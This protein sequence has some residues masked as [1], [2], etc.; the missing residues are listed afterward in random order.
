MSN[1]SPASEL[2][3]EVQQRLNAWQ[4]AFETRDVDGIMAFYADG[5][6]FSAFDL[7]PP[8][9]FH[10][11]DGWRQN[12]IYFFGL[13]DDDPQ[14]EFS[15]PELHVSGDLAV[16]KALVGLTGIIHGQ[17]TTM[18]ARQTVC[19][20]KQNGMW[21]MFHNHISVPADLASGQALTSLTPDHPTPAS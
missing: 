11:G 4:H 10:G 18:W 13:Y 3:N 20:Q 21:L 2:E 7:M 14:M 6:T 9:E 8:L 12:W 1:R 5:S 19:L 15:G 16:F 17:R